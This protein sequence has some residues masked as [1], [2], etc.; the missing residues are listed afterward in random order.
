[1]NEQF[2][3]DAVSLLDYRSHRGDERL[4]ALARPYLS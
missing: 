3:E 2:L 1:M 4:L